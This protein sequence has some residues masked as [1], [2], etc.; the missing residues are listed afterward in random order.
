MD[1][2]DVVEWANGHYTPSGIFTT[3]VLF[4]WAGEN[5]FVKPC[6]N[7]TVAI[8]NEMC[9]ESLSPDLFEK[10]EEI[11]NSL[12]ANRSALKDNLAK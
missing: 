8:V 9:I 1:S 4:K 7:N 3:E 2:G 12:K 10:W 11:K 5:G 6:E